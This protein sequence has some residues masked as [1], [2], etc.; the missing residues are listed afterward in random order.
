LAVA[1]EQ[2]KGSYAKKQQE[3]IVRLVLV[4]ILEEL[5]HRLLIAIQELVFLLKDAVWHRR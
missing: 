5:V 3:Q 1:K 2:I 4:S